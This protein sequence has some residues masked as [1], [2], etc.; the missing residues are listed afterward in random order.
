M[1]KGRIESKTK[2]KNPVCQMI[3]DPVKSKAGVENMGE[4][5]H[6]TQCLQ[7]WP[8]VERDI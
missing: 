4:E 7:G 5:C 6:L 3:N 8:E 2:T 1:G